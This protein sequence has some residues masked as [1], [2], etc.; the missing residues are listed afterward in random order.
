V[1]AQIAAEAPYGVRVLD[2]IRESDDPS[3]FFDAIHLQWTAVRTF[4][5]RLVQLVLAD[6]AAADSGQ[7]LSK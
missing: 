6:V 5:D 3:D 7:S 1:S 2:R 4:S